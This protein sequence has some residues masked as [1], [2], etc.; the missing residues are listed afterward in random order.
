MTINDSWGYQENDNNYKT[1][2]QIIDL[3]VDTLSKGGNLLLN[4]SPKPD[5]T[6]PEKQENIL[7]ELGKWTKKHQS[8]IYSTQKGIPYEHY[9]GPSTLNKEKN[10]LYLY[11]RDKPKNN[12]IVLKGISNKINRAYVVGNGTILNKQILCK[13][14]WNKYPGITY[15]KIP[16]NTLD[17]YYTVIALVLDGPIKLFKEKTGAV[18]LN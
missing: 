11:V 13:V 4:I 8:A 5:G 9:Y 12:E 6:V 1:P 16:E 2:L 10:I 18:E 3:F 14:Y 7:K 15:V 17:E